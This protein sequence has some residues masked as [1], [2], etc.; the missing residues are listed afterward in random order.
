MGNRG[1]KRG[2]SR[3]SPLFRPSTRPT[4]TIQQSSSNKSQAS[5]SADDLFVCQGSSLQLAS[6]AVRSFAYLCSCS[7]FFSLVCYKLFRSKAS[8]NWCC[9]EVFLEVTASVFWHPA[10]TGC[11]PRADRLRRPDNT[12]VL[13]TVRAVG[14][15]AMIVHGSQGEV[16]RYPILSWAGPGW[17]H[18]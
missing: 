15:K 9:T 7:C 16:I 1:S 10:T 13:P 18:G 6:S 3:V 12:V 8:I 14:T 11:V 17:V 2:K 5:D 4:W